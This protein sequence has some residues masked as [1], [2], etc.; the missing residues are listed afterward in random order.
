MTAVYSGALMMRFAVA[1]IRCFSRGRTVASLHVK[2][3]KIVVLSKLC[4]LC[5]SEQYFLEFCI[6]SR[7]RRNL[8]VNFT[9]R[10]MRV[11]E[12][13]HLFGNAEQIQCRVSIRFAATFVDEAE[14]F[15]IAKYLAQHLR[16]VLEHA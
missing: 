3:A 9:S 4:Q 5:E 12:S 7:A 13:L 16:P 2:P 10:Y 6:G 11:D 1:S 14:Q 15:G 8:R